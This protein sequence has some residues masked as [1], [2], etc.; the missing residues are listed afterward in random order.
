MISKEPRDD[1]VTHEFT[2]H[3]PLIIDYK[4]MG[5][6]AN[7]AVN[8][9]DLQLQRNKRNEIDISELIW[10]IFYERLSWRRR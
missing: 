10:R 8:V 9:F 4:R 6:A 5:N 2:K 3:P 1:A 7:A